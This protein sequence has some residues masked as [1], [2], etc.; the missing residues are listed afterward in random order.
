MKNLVAKKV[1]IV[2]TQEILQKRVLSMIYD[3]EIEQDEAVE[4][5]YVIKMTL[6]DE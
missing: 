3:C 6:E 5:F 1:M 2:Q 4:D